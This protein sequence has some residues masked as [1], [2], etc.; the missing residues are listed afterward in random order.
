MVKLFQSRRWRGRVVSNAGEL[1]HDP[2]P[3]W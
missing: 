2:A 3:N 1:P